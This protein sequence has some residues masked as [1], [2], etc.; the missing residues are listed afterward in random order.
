MPRSAIRSPRKPI[1]F[2][3]LRRELNEMWQPK[4]D[5][6]KGWTTMEWTRARGRSPGTRAQTCAHLKAMVKEGEWLLSRDIRIKMDGT[7]QPV[8]VYRP[9][10]PTKHW[11]PGMEPPK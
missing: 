2:D 1:S 4:P 8:T 11:K 6:T 10:K 7:K 5:Y 3:A 9:V